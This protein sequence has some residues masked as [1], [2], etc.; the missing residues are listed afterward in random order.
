MVPPDGIYL[1]GKRISFDSLPG[2][3]VVFKWTVDRMG[4]QVAMR[5]QVYFT[6]FREKVISLQFSTV[7][8]DA[9]FSR[10][11]PLFRLMANSVVVLS[12]YE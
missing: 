10:F 12:Q 2:G 6:F 5:W 3:L 8:N 11:E 4:Q 1:S 9:T 7:D